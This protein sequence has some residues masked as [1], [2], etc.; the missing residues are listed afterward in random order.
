MDQETEARWGRLIA[1]RA[2]ITKALEIA[3]REKIIGH[4]LEAEVLVLVA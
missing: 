3:R 2:E 4:P 1:L